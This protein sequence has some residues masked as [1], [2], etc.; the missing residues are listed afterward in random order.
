MGGVFLLTGTDTAVGKTFVGS[1][2][3]EACI[4][5]GIR[6]IAVK[7]IESGCAASKD[8]T[9]LPPDA[10]RYHALLGDSSV[11]L[12]DICF[13]R[14]GEPVSP[15]IAARRSG[16]LPDPRVIRDRILAEMGRRDVVL[17]EGAGGIM[18]EIVDGY[19]FLNLASDL[20]MAVIIVAPNRLGV[21]NHVAL[22][23]KTLRSSRI[24]VGGIILN[25]LSA[26]PDEA[27]RHN[28]EELKRV[29]GGCFLER[30]SFNAAAL[31]DGIIEQLFGKT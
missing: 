10:I 21:L 23:V 30:V 18:V 27:S 9:L 5:E 1:L 15:N 17:V 6:A 12:E 26:T 24:R 14:Y 22:T 19:A 16:R 4:R 8:G 2:L 11:T 7:P 20:A 13:Y 3:L 31:P 25:D 29:H 28:L